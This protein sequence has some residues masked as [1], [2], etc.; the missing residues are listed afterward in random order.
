MSSFASDAAGDLAGLSRSLR[1]GELDLIRHIGDLEDNFEAREP[2][3][4]AFVPEEGRFSRLR[5]EAG[6][7]LNAYPEPAARPPFFGISFGV[8]DVIHVDGLPTHAGSR[9]PEARLRG[10]EAAC[11]SR[12]KAQ[13]ALVL[14]KTVTAEFAFFAPGPTRNPHN[15]EHTPGGSSSGSAAAVAAGLAPLCF[16]TQTTGSVIRPAAFC[17]VVGF[18]PTRDRVSGDGYIHLAPSLDHVGLFTTDVKSAEMAASVLLEDWRGPAVS[19]SSR[20]VLGIPAGPYLAYGSQL[21]LAHFER[22]CERLTRAGYALKHVNAMAD[23]EEIMHRHHLII[24][25]EAA[26]VHRVWFDEFGDLYQPKT[27]DLVHRGRSVSPEALIR[28]LEG[29]RALRDTLMSLMDEHGLDGWITPAAPGPAPLG[30]E[31]TGNPVMNLPWTHSGLPALNIPSGTTAD[32]LPLGSQIVG[33]WDKDETL[34][35][36]GKVIE[37]DLNPGRDGDR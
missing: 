17:G 15:L 13:G 12:L 33:R 19:P 7:L 29:R 27:A 26:Q 24:D 21:S 18:K 37:R 5:R 11:V 1:S 9:V 25:G 6:E 20:P 30:L 22:A 36:F 34:L 3:V 4:R 10:P 35:A 2:Q 31:S 8:K 16:G 14:G 28:A 32:G 23:Y